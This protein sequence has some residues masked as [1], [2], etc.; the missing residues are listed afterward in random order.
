M[1]G[2]WWRREREKYSQGSRQILDG[3]G[4]WKSEGGGG[5]KN[6][7]ELRQILDGMVEWKC[8]VVEERERKVYPG[9]KADT[10]WNGGV[11]E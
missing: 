6:I 2:R 7:E 10:G 4:E 5:E 9:I 3:M 11:E 1:R 8:Q